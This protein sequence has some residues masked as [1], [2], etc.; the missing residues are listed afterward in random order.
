MTARGLVQGVGFRPFVHRLA[1]ELGLAGLV[2]NDLLGARIEVEGTLPRLAAFVARLRA[3][4]PAPGYIE[5]LDQELL[6]ATGEPGFVIGASC[7]GGLAEAWVLP[8]LATCPECRRELFD[9]ADRRLGYPF[10][11]CTHCGPRF[12]IVRDL[13]YDRANTTMAGFALCPDCQREYDDPADRRFHAQPTACAVCGPRLASALDDATARLH[14]GQIVAVKGLGGYHL[15]V[16]ARN[17]DAIRRLRDRKHREAKPLAVMVAGLDEARGIAAVSAAE[18]ELLTSPAAPIVLLSPRADNGLAPSVAPGQTTLGVMLA[19]TPLHHLLLAAMAGP[20]VMTSGNLTDEPIAYVD[21]EVRTRLDGVADAILSHNRPIERRCDDSVVR[22]WRGRLLPYRRSR[23][24]APVPLALD[25][26]GEATVLAVGSHQKN[27]FCLTRGGEAFLSHHIGDLEN[28]L[29]LAAFETGIADFER[30]FRLQPTVLAHDLH[31]DYWATRY[32]LER[33]VREGQVLVG[34]QHHHAHLAACLADNGR[35]DRLLGVCFDGTG[36]GPDGS[37]WGGEILLGDRRDYRRVGRLRPFVLPGGESA[38]RQGWRVAVALAAQAGVSLDAARLG[39]EPE[40]FDAVAAMVA[41]GFA[42]LPT[43][44]A[45]RLFDAAAALAGVGSVSRYE[46]EAAILLEGACRAGGDV[47][48]F[49]VSAD[50]IDW[51]PAVDWLWRRSG[52]AAGAFHRGLAEATARL[53]ERLREQHSVA[54][55]ALSGG[56]MQNVTL[57]SELADRLHNRGFEVLTHRRVPPNDGGL[58]LGQAAVARARLAGD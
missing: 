55:V 56:C 57:L 5:R 39:V 4:L 53:C 40:R 8:D 54:V 25:D 26:H 36:W 44:S 17:D 12:S 3:E 10:L 2:R 1:G 29:A 14:A 23:G 49:D 42:C 21:A 20:L 13:P 35:H 16:D 50:E 6:P 18:A 7:A 45:G 46:G 24:Y 41:S 47:A 38:V 19:Y 28:D 33:A 48:P 15:A 32:A 43:S 27:T 51:R 31:P 30:L 34:V 37:V 9:P 22:V 11:N 52:P 58:S